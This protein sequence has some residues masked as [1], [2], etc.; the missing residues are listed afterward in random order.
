MTLNME[1]MTIREYRRV[2]LFVCCLIMCL[3]VLCCDIRYDFRMKT[4]FSSIRL[5]PLVVCWRAH[6]IFTLI[7]FVGV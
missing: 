6:V 3:Y 1:S 2:H 4:M 5:L 7:M